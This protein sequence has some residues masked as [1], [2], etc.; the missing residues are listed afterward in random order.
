MYESEIQGILL[1]EKNSLPQNTLYLFRH[2][3]AETWA[4]QRL[5]FPAESRTLSYS[6]AL[7]SPPK[8]CTS[9]GS[10]DTNFTSN[11]PLGAILRVYQT[12]LQSWP[13]RASSDLFELLQT[14][15][16]IQFGACT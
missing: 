3:T 8:Y 12:H 5:S 10:H 15:Y 4:P 9:L 16:V 7:A 14:N 2:K 11:L 13:Q 1:R 6:A